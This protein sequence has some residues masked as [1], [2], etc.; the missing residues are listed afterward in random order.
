MSIVSS[1]GELCS[2]LPNH[3]NASYL[4]N[5]IILITIC[6]ILHTLRREKEVVFRFNEMLKLA[7]YL[8]LLVAALVVDLS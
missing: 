1:F 8:P 4:A 3:N 5:F 6:M 2:H 7:F